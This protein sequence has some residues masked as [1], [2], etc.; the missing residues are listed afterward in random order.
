MNDFES[1]FY[2]MFVGC[3]TWWRS[4]WLI[5]LMPSIPEDPVDR[6]HR[7][8]GCRVTDSLCQELLSYL[9]GKHA[10]LLCLK[11]NYSFHHRWRCHLLRFSSSNG[12]RLDWPSLVKPSQDFWHTSMGDKQL[13]ATCQSEVFSGFYPS[14]LPWDV[15]WPDPH[16]SQLHYPP[17]HI[18][19]QGS[20]I[21]KN[22]S[23]LVNPSLTCNMLCKNLNIINGW[24]NLVWTSKVW[25]FEIWALV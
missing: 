1:C 4:V 17:P 11:S 3:N 14:S 20:P 5:D 7:W 2:K 8:D 21:H 10:R 25:N 13:P 22:S 9:P 19:W 16:E 6:G 18:V 24:S 23:Q 15:T 12:S